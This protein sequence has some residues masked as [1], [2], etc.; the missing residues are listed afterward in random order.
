MKLI[1]IRGKHSPMFGRDILFAEACFP[2]MV[3]IW[4]FKVKIW[5]F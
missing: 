2:A 3:A 1:G 4:P 5:P